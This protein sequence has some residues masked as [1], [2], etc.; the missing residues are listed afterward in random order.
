MTISDFSYD[1]V[2]RLHGHHAS[3]GAFKDAINR[4]NQ[5]LLACLAAEGIE[6]PYPTAVEIQKAA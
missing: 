6:I 4:L 5:D 2:F 1:F 3:F